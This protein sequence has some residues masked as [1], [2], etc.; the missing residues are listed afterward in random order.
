MEKSISCWR[1]QSLAS[2]C[3]CRCCFRSAHAYLRE[4][5]GPK[6]SRRKC[7]CRNPRANAR[8]LVHRSDASAC[9]ANGGDRCDRVRFAPIADA[10]G[11]TTFVWLLLFL[12][13][14]EHTSELQS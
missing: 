4:L 1:E 14:E 3:R 9:N 5:C 10:D 6:V 12:R 2:P 8:H 13:S 7:D 11:H